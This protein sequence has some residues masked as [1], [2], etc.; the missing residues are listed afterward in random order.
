MPIQLTER[1]RGGLPVFAAVAVALLL[2]AVAWGAS[3][4]DAAKDA[5]VVGERRNGYI[6]LVVKNPTPEQ[7]ALVKDVNQRRRARYTEIAQSSGATPDQVAARAAQRLIR[8]A[9]PGH[10]VQAAGG[11]WVRKP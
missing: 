11:E 6:G 9:K 7:K 3:A 4:L 1:N 10:Y 5:G 2:A 8:E